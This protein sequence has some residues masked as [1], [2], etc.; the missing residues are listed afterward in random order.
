[1]CTPLTVFG[2]L[3]VWAVPL[4][5]TARDGGEDVSVAITAAR[6][7]GW[8]LP[9][10]GQ[11]TAC[12]WSVFAAVAAASLTA[13]RVLEAHADALAILAEAGECPPP[14]LV[15]GVFA[16][17]AGGCRLGAEIASDGRTAALSGTKPW[18]SLAAD[19]DAALVTAHSPEGRR[20]FQVDLRDPAVQ[21]EP[22]RRWVARGLRAVT[23]TPVR[24]DAAR[25]TALGPVDWYLTRSG[26][27]WGGLGVAAC[28]YGGALGLVTAIRRRAVDSGADV[29][30]LHLGGAD[31]A[32]HAARVC[33]AEAAQ[34]I[35]ANHA[36]DASLL[37][38]R[39]RSVVAD[40]VETILRHA[41]HAL[42]PGPLALDGD[43]AARVADLEL[44]VRQHHAERDLIA[45]GRTLFEPSAQT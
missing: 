14:D 45:L 15:W 37:A 28:W 19:L 16:A 42:G 24:F 18:C 43:H 40:A 12:R 30:A 13:A 9:L 8:R 25:A 35:D 2:E 41:A 10:P 26:F 11:D 22:P 27:A 17:E 3:P 7:S 34:L 36:G 23:S 6:D 20:L 31:V 5:E 29:D 44:Y 21:P 32:L 1:M 38:L 39:V 4:V 33:L